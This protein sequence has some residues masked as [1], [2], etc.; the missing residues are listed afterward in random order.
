[1]IGL[2]IIGSLSYN[3]LHR[4]AREEMLK[5]ASVLMEAAL[6][7]RQYTIKEIKPLLAIQNKR[8]FLPQSVPSYAATQN[9]Q[10]FRKTHPEYRYKEATLN[11]T[12]P[13]DRATD[14]EA[15]LIQ[16]FRN[17]ADKNHITLVRDT[18]MGK[19]L[20]YARPI[21]IENQECLTCHGI[22]E[23]APKSMIKLYG[24]A[25]GFGWKMNEVVGSQIVSVPLSIPIQRANATF[26]TL[27]SVTAGIFLSIYLILIF[28]FKNLFFDRVMTLT[29]VVEKLAQVKN[30]T[31]KDVVAWANEVE[32]KEGN[33]KNVTVHA[34]ETTQSKD[35]DRAN[36]E[37]AKD[38]EVVQ[39]KEE[40]LVT[41]TDSMYELSDYLEQTD[42][43]ELL[44][45]QSISLKNMYQKPFMHASYIDDAF[46]IEDVITELTQDSCLVSEK[47]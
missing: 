40:D 7:M 15:K 24:P 19:S 35:I 11:P 39:A 9:F 45:A 3:I 5:Q 32:N 37:L 30:T 22:I 28:F 12:N 33:N 4:H 42:S 8:R 26:Y 16:K 21:R 43:D 44:D 20:Y 27:S 25:N 36:E 47:K 18:P 6:A 17:N 31:Q 2:V 10:V 41:D 13:R 14:W 29:S 1:M 38:K 46:E 23:D 34:T